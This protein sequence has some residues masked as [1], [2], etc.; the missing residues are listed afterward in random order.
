MTETCKG[1]VSE[2]YQEEKLKKLAFEN[3][4]STVRSSVHIFSNSDMNG[5]VFFY[6]SCYEGGVAKT[7]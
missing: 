6:L 5:R 3:P 4:S 2:F 7:Q 1:L